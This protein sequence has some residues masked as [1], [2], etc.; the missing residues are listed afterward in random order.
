M[1]FFETTLYLWRFYNKTIK[2]H[3][4]IKQL[5][6]KWRQVFLKRQIKKVESRERMIGFYFYLWHSEIMF[7]ITFKLTNHKKNYELSK[8]CI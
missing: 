3:F 7:Q 2:Y 5:F 8:M 1:L 6:S 4:R